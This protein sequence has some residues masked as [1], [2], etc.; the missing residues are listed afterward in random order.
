MQVPAQ[1]VSSLIENS[2]TGK[3]FEDI[4]GTTLGQ[5]ATSLAEVCPTG[6]KTTAPLIIGPEYKLGELLNTAKTVFPIIANPPPAV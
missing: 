1:I 3:G 2:A 6:A 4:E 5:V